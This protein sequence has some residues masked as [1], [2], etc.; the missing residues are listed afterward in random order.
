MPLLFA[1]IMVDFFDTLGTA[2]AIPN[3]SELHD[4][5]GKILGLRELLIVDSASAS[6]G[7][8]CGASSVTSY[9]ESAAG[10]AEAAR[11][12]RHSVIVDLLFLAVL[13]LAP[14]AAVVPACATAPALILVGFLMIGQMARI[15]FDDTQIAI[16]AFFTL[17]MI[18]LT[19]S[20]AHGIG[21]GFIA[22][23]VIKI[24]AGRFREVHP[25][26]YLASAAFAFYFVT[27]ALA[28]KAAA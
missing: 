12:G 14:V 19:Y 3:Q 24:V 2:T 9:I 4:R 21:Y 26:M 18:P 10:V 7:G 20:I 6:I 23:V 28:K 5:Q 27:E 13:F 17:L 25:L 11:T 1:V 15:D 16:P 8:I 22:F